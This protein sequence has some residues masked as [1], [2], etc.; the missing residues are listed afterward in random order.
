MNRGNFVRIFFILSVCVFLSSLASLACAADHT[1]TIVNSSNTALKPA[2]TPHV[3]TYNTTT[4]C[5][6]LPPAACSQINLTPVPSST[7]TIAAGGSLT[8]KMSGPDG[9][10]IAGLQ[11][12]WLPNIKGKV[13]YVTCQ[14]SPVNQCNNSGASNWKCTISQANMDTAKNN[15]IA[16]GTVTAQ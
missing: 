11:T 5:S 13:Q 4:L 3:V 16:N 2:N 10:N 15:Q 1:I 6:S 9:C 8:L 7:T 12:N 14:K